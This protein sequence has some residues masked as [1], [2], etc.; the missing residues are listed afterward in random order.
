MHS[1]TAAAAAAL[2]CPSLQRA[3]V[4]AKPCVADSRR[5]SSTRSFVADILPG[6]GET[7]AL[8][9]QMGLTPHVLRD[10][11]NMAKHFKLHGKKAESCNGGA[12]GPIC[13]ASST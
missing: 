13:G 10:T 6:R 1:S 11:F 9:R 3:K 4:L 2:R 5:H 8:S 12:P 7:S